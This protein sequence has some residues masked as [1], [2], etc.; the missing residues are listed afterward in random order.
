MPVECGVE[1]EFFLQVPAFLRYNGNHSLF[2][3]I[4]TKVNV[5]KSSIQ[6]R[7]VRKLRR[8]ALV[9]TVHFP[10]DRES[11]I[12]ILLLRTQKIGRADSR[13][14]DVERMFLKN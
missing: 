12:A 13:I 7:K 5:F 11:G 6:R 3:S 4:V 14:N 9:S 1:P 2:H 8:I 10:K